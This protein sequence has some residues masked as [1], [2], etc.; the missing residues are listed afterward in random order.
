[1]GLNGIQFVCED[2]N[3]NENPT[4]VQ[5]PSKGWTA[6]LQS[7]PKFGFFMSAVIFKYEVNGKFTGINFGY[8]GVP[9]ISKL[10]F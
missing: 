2:I 6:P 10:V 1:M 4:T 8:S 5:D 7:P 3:L 9:V